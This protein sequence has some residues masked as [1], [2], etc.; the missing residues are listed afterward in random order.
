[1]YSEAKKHQTGESARISELRGAIIE[2]KG[3]GRG[4]GKG[5]GRDDDLEGFI[6]SDEHTSNTSDEGAD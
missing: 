1:M 3:K 5:K 6:V 2:G 4:R